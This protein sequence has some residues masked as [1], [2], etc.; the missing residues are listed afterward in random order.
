MKRV[1]RARAVAMCLLLGMGLAEVLAGPGTLVPR[2]PPRGWISLN[3]ADAR[4][5]EVVPGVGPVRARA[6]V[7]LRRQRGAFRSLEE[8][9]EISGIGEETLAGMAPFVSIHRHPMVPRRE[10]E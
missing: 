2:A 8:L 1:E 4:T 5:L 3:G 10:S 7:A 6:I 9:A